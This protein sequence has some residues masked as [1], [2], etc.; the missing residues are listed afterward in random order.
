MKWFFNLSKWKKRII[1]TI[2]LALCFILLL[3]NQLLLGAIF[4]ILSIP[5]IFLLERAERLEKKA[6]EVS[7]NSSSPANSM[8]LYKHLTFNLVETCNPCTYRAIYWHDGKFQ[9]LIPQVYTIEVNDGH[10]D[11]LVNNEKLG[12]IPSKNFDE[13]NKIF[14]YIAKIELE[15]EHDTELEDN[16][17]SPVVSIIYYTEEKLKFLPDFEFIN[18]GQRIS[19]YHKPTFIEEY[20][21]ID[22]E[23][24]GLNPIFDD[25]I[26][27]AALHIKDGKVVNRFSEFVYSEKITNE[28]TTINH[29]SSA[30]VNNARKASEVLNDFADFIQDLPLLGHNISFDLDFICA[31][32]PISNNFED[33]CALSK[34]YLYKNNCGISVSNCKLDTICSALDIKFSSSH[35]A[36]VDCERTYQCYEKIKSLIKN[37]ILQFS[38][39]E[40]L[41][42]EEKNI[43][44]EKYEKI[45][46]SQAIALYEENVADNFDGSYPYNR[47]ITIYKKQKRLLDAIRVAERAIYVFDKVVNDER[48]DRV[49][50]LENYKETL[51][52]LNQSLNNK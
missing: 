51:K 11:F 36:E 37:P 21:V 50:K 19:S 15:I 40:K 12:E 44:A 47:L 29:I 9:R 17:Y 41:S 6:N 24:T 13:V 30:D 31:V 34:E 26:E 38:N 52:K 5:F 20:I 18:R 33:T 16:D 2:P 49:N 3:A 28:S 8:P 32:H 23:T 1:C 25:I 39:K 10:F 4:F 48:G 42:G 45:D 7:K 35:R 22:V 43:L 14:P 27:I 46:I